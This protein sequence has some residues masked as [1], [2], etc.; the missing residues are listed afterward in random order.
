MKVKKMCKRYTAAPSGT[1]GRMLSHSAYGLLT[2][3]WQAKRITEQGPW[4]RLYP[5]LPAL[6]VPQEW[7]LWSSRLRD[8]PHS[9]QKPPVARPLVLAPVHLRAS[10]G[11]LGRGL[12][13][14][15]GWSGG[16]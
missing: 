2:V 3:H 12:S 9:D 15:P 4:A 11:R 7:A 10:E 1:W 8:P 16:S 5:L 13:I 6:P 14:E